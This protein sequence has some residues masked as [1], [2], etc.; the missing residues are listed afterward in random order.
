MIAFGTVSPI[1]T[2]FA[3]TVWL[4]DNGK[5]ELAL[6]RSY[7]EFILRTPPEF[8]YPDR[9]KDYA[10]LFE[11]FGLL[12]GGGFFELGEAYM[13]F[14]LLGTLVA[15]GVL[16]FLMAKT[17]YNVIARQTVLSYFLLFTFLGVF[18]RGTWYQTFAFYRGFWTAIIL[19]WAIVAAHQLM[20]GAATTH[21]RVPPARGAI[22]SS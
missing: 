11:E 17:F 12:A 22:Q 18:L 4:V 20:M 8:L 13:N 3:N 7:W 16:S 14:G 5:L 10:W 6:G 9:P 1:S 21:T 15:P 2:T 19:Y